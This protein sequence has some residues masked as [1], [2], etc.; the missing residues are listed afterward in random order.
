MTDEIMSRR[1]LVEKTLY[2]DLLRE[3][4]MSFRSSAAFCR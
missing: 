1:T 2:A 4:T 3:M